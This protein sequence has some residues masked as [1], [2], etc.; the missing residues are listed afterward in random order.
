MTVELDTDAIRKFEQACRLFPEILREEI[1]K[2]VG[3][4]AYKIEGKAKELCPRATGN[5]RG[6]IHAVVR[7]WADA[8]VA[9]NVSYAADVEFGTDAHDIEPRGAKALAFDVQIGKKLTPK[10]RGKNKR[11]ETTKITGTIFRRR[12]HH[13]GTKA[14]P[15]LEPA[16]LYGQSIAP[17]VFGEALDLALER[18]QRSLT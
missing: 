17:K 8:F 16:F 11:I 12:V 2:A 14:Q 7:T 15:F 18:Y 1:G 10:G 9:T 4:L 3:T 13:P 5:L 6:S